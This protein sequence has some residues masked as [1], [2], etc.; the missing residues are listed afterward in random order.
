MS[1]R[2]DERMKMTS[3]IWYKIFI[4]QECEGGKSRSF[5]SRRQAAKW[6]ELN[7]KLMPPE[8]GGSTAKQERHSAGI[9]S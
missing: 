6:A 9:S 4:F 5:Q 7:G 8:L 3:G 1:W 2:V